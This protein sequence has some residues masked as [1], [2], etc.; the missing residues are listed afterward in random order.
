MKSETHTK[1][2]KKMCPFEFDEDQNCVRD[3]IGGDCIEENKVI[4]KDRYGHCYDVEAILQYMYHKIPKLECRVRY[5]RSDKDYPQMLLN[6]ENYQPPGHE[7]V[8]KYEEEEMKNSVHTKIFLNQNKYMNQI[9]NLIQ[10]Y[11]EEVDGDEP[12]K[13]NS[14]FREPYDANDVIDFIFGY[15]MDPMRSL[16][17][18][19]DTQMAIYSAKNPADPDVKLYQTIKNLLSQ[20]YLGVPDR[21]LKPQIDYLVNTRFIMDKG[22]TDRDV[23][24]SMISCL[25]GHDMSARERQQ[26]IYFLN[27]TLDM[28]IDYFNEKHH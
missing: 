18:E 28:F 19:F 25:D 16:T 7:Q 4:H 17:G 8:E 10:N 11:E 3:H 13:F 14:I 24:I 26:A 9:A 6:Y 12:K 15:Y 2:L 21:G 23:L 5:L 27:L 1:K 22:E 20:A